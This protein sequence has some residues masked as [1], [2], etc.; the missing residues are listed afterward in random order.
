MRRLSFNRSE[1]AKKSDQNIPKN[2][3]RT[4]IA[5]RMVETRAEL[6][7]PGIRSSTLSHDQAARGGVFTIWRYQPVLV[8]RE[9]H[10]MIHPEGRFRRGPQ[11]ERDTRQHFSRS[12]AA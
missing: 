6:P 9:D 4:T 1:P 8:R 12:R 5:E 7:L 11:N 3:C 2:H 10:G